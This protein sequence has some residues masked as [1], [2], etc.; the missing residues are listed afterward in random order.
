MSIF[1]RPLLVR[2]ALSVV[3]PVMMSGH[4]AQAAART[5]LDPAHAYTFQELLTAGTQ[6]NSAVAQ[7]R[8]DVESLRWERLA[9]WGRLMPTL[10]AGFSY[11]LAVH[12]RFTYE[13]ND[14]RVVVLPGGQTSSGTSSS[15]TLSLN[16]TLFAGFANTAAL[17]RAL[18]VQEDV[19]GADTYQQ[20]QLRHDLM[21]AAHAVMASTSRRE[22]EQTLLEE[23]HKQLELARL[24]L[25]VG[26]GTELDVLQMELDVGR[27]QVSVEAA[28]QEQRSAWDQLALLVGA[29]PGPPGR[30]D[31]P[32]TV[33]EP[34]WSEEELTRQALA[35]REDLLSGRRGL[36]QARLQTVEA[37]AGFLPTLSLRAGHS[38]SEQRS[39][40]QTWEPIPQNY[41][42]SASLVLAV[43]IFQGFSTLNNWQGGRIEQRRQAVVQEQLERQV[44]AQIRE[45]L[46]RL[47][48]AWT[49]SG[50]TASNLELA[51][52][53]L[54]L[55]RERYQLGL[56]SLLQV[57]SAEAVWRQA[58]NEDLAQRLAFRDRLAEL[59][60]ATGAPLAGH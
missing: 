60:L 16:Q 13:D 48:S 40:Y 55:E 37:R 2:F 28:D 44:R 41:D 36:E 24:R 45:A 7:T 34:A 53:S 57:Q 3:L 18:L 42:N 27:Q 15:L 6:G 12:D 30:L 35:Q 19:R 20:Q 14:G 25:Q 43:P 8:L 10:S 1:T 56:S 47:R 59:E 9:A 29:D 46:L 32:F 51:R 23:R 5:A 11:G 22:T 49:Q 38:Q 31:M 17:K 50:T 54:A 39:G 4:P 33:F 21:K 26:K 52:R 58:E